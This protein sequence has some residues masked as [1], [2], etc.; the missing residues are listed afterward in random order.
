MEDEASV[1]NAGV[2]YWVERLLKYVALLGG[3]FL[4]ALMILVSV[5]VFFRYQLNKPILGD[6]EL[7]EIGMSLVVM[8]AMPYV[9]LRGAHIRVDILD[10]YIGSYGRFFGDVFARVVSC[11]VLCL[12]I[13]KT[14]NKTLD[15]HEYGDVTNMIEI[16]VAIAYGA[17]TVGFGLSIL[18]LAGQL[19]SQFR[20]GIT[21]YE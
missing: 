15:A 6:T 13:G 16:P 12:L 8:L 4:F 7:V 14:W 1:G 9:T 3:L 19:F 17:I 2:P 20:T 18:V 21:N 11:F 5:A 10:R